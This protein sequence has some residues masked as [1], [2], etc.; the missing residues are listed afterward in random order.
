MLGGNLSGAVL[1]PPGRIGENGGELAAP[2][3]A[4]EIVTMR[5]RELQQWYCQ[6]H[7]LCRIRQ[8][9]RH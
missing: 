5:E 7:A 1:K 6:A 4:D 3:P 2:S 9:R 8:S